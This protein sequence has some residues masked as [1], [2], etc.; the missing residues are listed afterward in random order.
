MHPC[1]KPLLAS[2]R[3]RGCWVLLINS[4]PYSPTSAVSA[5]V[6]CFISPICYS[7]M[8]PDTGRLTWWILINYMDWSIDRY[9]SVY[10]GVRTLDSCQSHTL[11]LL[12]LKQN[13]LHIRYKVLP[14]PFAEVCKVRHCQGQ[15][16][17]NNECTSNNSRKPKSRSC[18]CWGS[19]QRQSTESQPCIA[20]PAAQRLQTSINLRVQWWVTKTYCH[21]L[22][23]AVIWMYTFN[24][25]VSCVRSNRSH[26]LS[27]LPVL[28]YFSFEL[29]LVISMLW[30]YVW[31][32]TWC[33]L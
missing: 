30:H 27:L 32:L 9:N 15:G 16:H 21:E 19:N 22:H 7:A 23:D 6:C 17:C 12:C 33:S 5:G 31:F 4:S 10:S 1:A 26:V 13:I 3:R 28:I 14:K 29:M 8:T 11:Y 2:Y 25:L 18:P 20:G 24:D